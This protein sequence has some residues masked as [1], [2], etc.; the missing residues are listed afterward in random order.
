M[1]EFGIAMRI[2][3]AGP[4]ADARRNVPPSSATW[5]CMHGPQG[6]A[7]RRRRRPGLHAFGIGL[8]VNPDHLD[9]HD[10]EMGESPGAGVAS[11]SLALTPVLTFTPSTTL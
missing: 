4:G 3:V 5:A 6:S 9:G 11:L 10:A 7:R 8:E 1:S 2:P